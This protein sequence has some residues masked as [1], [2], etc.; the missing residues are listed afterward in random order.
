MTDS[1]RWSKFV[2]LPNAIS[3][4]GLLAVSEDFLSHE[5][6]DMLKV[7]WLSNTVIVSSIWK[8]TPNL[9]VGF[10]DSKE[11]S[12]VGWSGH[13]LHFSDMLGLSLYNNS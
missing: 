5:G 3:A 6:E 12:H 8:C 9:A 4:A 7:A 13:K 11:L 2:E 10:A 1:R